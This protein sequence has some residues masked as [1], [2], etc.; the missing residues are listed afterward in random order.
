MAVLDYFKNLRYNEGLLLAKA[1]LRLGYKVEVVDP[2]AKFWKIKGDGVELLFKL[3]GNP[4]NP[5][6]SLGPRQAT[7]NKRVAKV[8]MEKNGVPTPRYHIC[9]DEKDLSRIIAKYKF[10]VIIKSIYGSLGKRV[11]M[12]NDIKEAKKWFSLAQKRSKSV[13]IEEFV[14]GNDYRVLVLLGEVVAACQRVPPFVVGDGK[15]TIEELISQE[16]K[17]REEINK[18]KKIIVYHKIKV[19]EKLFSYLKSIGK[20]LDYVPQKGEKIRVALTANWSAGGH[21]IDVTE[22]IHPT[23]KKIAIDTCKA[24]NVFY[25]GVDIITKDITKDYRDVHGWVLEVNGRAEFSL[26]QIVHEGK[27]RDIASL[28]IKSLIRY[29]KTIERLKPVY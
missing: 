15:S 20:S 27:K 23:F 18:R 16:N 26:H 29:K 25:G 6:V 9:H 22:K 14:K 11:Y 4:K 21:L 2:A 13:I 10:P 17:K 1:A 3:F 12:A 5:L 28:L 7:K 24:C 8:L 19:D